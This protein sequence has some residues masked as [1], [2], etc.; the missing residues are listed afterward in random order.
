MDITPRQGAYGALFLLLVIALSVGC[1][2]VPSYPPPDGSGAVWITYHRTGGIA[3]FDDRLIIYENRTAAVAR[4]DPSL[5][6]LAGEFILTETEAGNLN[7]LFQQARFL[8]LNHFYP[9]PTPGADYFTYLIGYR[10]Y[11]I[12][13]EDTGVPGDLVPIIQELNRL[14]E[15]GCSGDVCTVP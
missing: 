6:P 11:E 15:S 7:A 9:A 5:G 14:L 12:Q 10:G 1:M 4:R 3:A 2:N 13:T 8:E